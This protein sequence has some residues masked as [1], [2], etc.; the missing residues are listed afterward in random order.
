[1]T[2]TRLAGLGI[3]LVAAA[4]MFG[5][6]ASSASAGAPYTAYGVGLKPGAVITATLGGKACGPGVTVDALGNWLMWISDTA[7]CS[8][9]EGNLVALAIDGQL[10]EQTITWTEGGAPANPAKGIALTVAVTVKPPVA[11]PTPSAAGF[12]GGVIS[13]VGSSIV[14]FT[15]SAIQLNAAGEAVK[16]RSVSA[17]IAGRLLTFVVGAP[18]F[19]NTEFDG[20]FSTGLNGTLVIVTV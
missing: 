5:I 6:M 4:T 11:P 9:R 2:S 17:T 12:S 19:V 14:I 3:A 10:A 7:P 8:P 18:G 15:G 16:A 13:P 1:M 20:A